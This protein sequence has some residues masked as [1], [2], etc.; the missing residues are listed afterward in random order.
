M[1]F[2]RK[3]F[4]AIFKE[5]VNRLSANIPNEVT[6]QRYS[7]LKAQSYMSVCGPWCKG[8]LCTNSTVKHPQ[9]HIQQRYRNSVCILWEE[10]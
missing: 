7:F 8:R 6:F 1:D 4:F 5:N 3:M 9:T 2:G 10:E